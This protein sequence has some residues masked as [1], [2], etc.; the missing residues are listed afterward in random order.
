M[1]MSIISA[2]KLILTLDCDES[3]HLLSDAMDRRLT[4]V[5]RLALVLHLMI[6]RNCRRFRRR[7]RFLAAAVRRLASATAPAAPSAAASLSPEARN[8]IEGAL[9]R[10]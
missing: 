4:P 10:G 6:C 5:E 8:R 7:L 1:A 3:S 9:R 2:A